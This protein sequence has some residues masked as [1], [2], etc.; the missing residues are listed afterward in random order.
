MC[1]APGCL[2][3]QLHHVEVPQAKGHVMGMV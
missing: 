2:S 3:V 1:E